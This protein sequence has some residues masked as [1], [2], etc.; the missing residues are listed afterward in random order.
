VWRRRL[1]GKRQ[2]STL[3]LSNR[4]RGGDLVGDDSGGHDT[5]LA[6]AFGGV[7][8]RIGTL[9][10]VFERLAGSLNDDPGTE[11]HDDVPVRQ[12]VGGQVTLKARN[13]RCRFGKT[14]FRQQQDKLFAPKRHRISEG[15]RAARRPLA[16]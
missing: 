8:R 1:P 4:A 2:S 16:R 15:R 9:E 12:G 10:R 14:G 11:G 13:R 5:V 6:G 7:G 3:L